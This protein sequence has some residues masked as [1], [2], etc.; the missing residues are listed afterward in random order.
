MSEKPVF[1]LLTDNRERIGKS[2]Y[3]KSK[4]D[5]DVISSFRIADRV[6]FVYKDFVHKIIL[7]NETS[8]PDTISEYACNGDFER[9]EDETTEIDFCEF[10]V[11][12][13]KYNWTFQTFVGHMKPG[14]ELELIWELDSQVTDELLNKNLHVDTLVAILFTGKEYQHHFIIGTIVGSEE[15]GTRMVMTNT[16]EAMNEQ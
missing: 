2:R 16:N 5:I 11:F 7:I 12:F 13:S 6:R 15:L 8:E 10:E 3:R 9:N 14:Q 1:T 4:L